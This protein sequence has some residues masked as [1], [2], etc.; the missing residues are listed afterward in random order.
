VV[1]PTTPHPFHLDIALSALQKL[2]NLRPTFLYYSHFGKAH[3]AVERLR[4]YGKQLELWAETAKEGIESGEDVEAIGRRILQR[5]EALKEVAEYIR[6]HPI[7]SKT[8][9]RESV[10]GITRFVERHLASSE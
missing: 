10:E 9:L 1:V 8:I 7:W 3:N 6:G 2:A 5:D 4:G